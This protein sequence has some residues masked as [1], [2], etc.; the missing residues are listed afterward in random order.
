MR[1]KILVL[2]LIFLIIACISSPP[3]PLITEYEKELATE[4]IKEYRGIRD[5]AIGQEGDTVSLALIVDY[6]ISKEYAK[7]LG[8]NFLRL[9]MTHSKDSDPGK[10]LRRGIYDYI[11]GVYYPNKKE[12]VTGAKSMIGINI[13]W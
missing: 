2:G 12:V 5:A 13:T 10:E 4:M 6:G 3:A 9:T 11:I 1:I 8:E 7:E